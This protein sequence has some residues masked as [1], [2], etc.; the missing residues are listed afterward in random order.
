MNNKNKSKK[1]YW[2]KL[3]EPLIT[4]A[5]VINLINN[6]NGLGFKAWYLYQRLI[7]L[8]ANN[9][10]RLVFNIDNDS[11]K[12]FTIPDIASMTGTIDTQEIKKCLNMLIA[13]NLVSKQD[14]LYR[15]IDIDNLV[16]N[17]TLG[18]LEK[19]RQRNL[20]KAKSTT[21][22]EISL[23]NDNDELLEAQA[24]TLV[25]YLYEIQYI[26]SMTNFD[27]VDKA[28]REMKSLINTYSMD[29]VKQGLEYVIQASTDRD[30]NG[31]VVRHRFKP[32]GQS[33]ELDYLFKGIHDQCGKRQA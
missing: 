19:Q 26:L 31:K 11:E 15:I 20:S 30:D 18:A 12:P 23:L 10:G 5:K 14:K 1:F 3:T 7:L 4:S 24:N 27:V 17:Q 13:I 22:N 9:S 16:G 28:I 29:K 2:F 8:S 32:M 33:G 25:N 6:K 21:D